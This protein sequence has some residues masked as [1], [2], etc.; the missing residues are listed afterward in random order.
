MSKEINP[1]TQYGWN[2]WK[3]VFEVICD[4]R[5][6][7]RL[8]G[9]VHKSVVRPT[10]TYGL[11][12]APLKKT[13]EKRLD[14]AEMKMLRW[15]SGVTL[16]DKVRNEYIR[17]SVKVT[18]VSKKVQEARLRWFGHI[19]RREDEEQHVAREAMSMEVEGTRRRGRPRIRW[20]DCIRS[21]MR[22]KGLSRRSAGNR[23]LW[24]RLIKN[25][26]PE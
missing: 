21:D 2:D 20:K 16:R 19:T 1:C 18:E 3:L 11:E 8:K 26:D 12:A 17:G 5:V 4:R 14:V 22:E 7:I 25:G 6:P 13:E 23:N 9:K 10:M 24:K 15:M